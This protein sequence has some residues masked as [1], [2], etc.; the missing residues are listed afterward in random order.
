MGCVCLSRDSR[1]SRERAYLSVI[2]AEA[3]RGNARMISDAA[4]EGDNSRGQHSNSMR[5]TSIA[6]I[7]HKDHKR[8]HYATHAR[9]LSD[10]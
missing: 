3:S 8:Q 2:S 7:G 6:L 10:I 9:A 4:Y 1:S 5:T